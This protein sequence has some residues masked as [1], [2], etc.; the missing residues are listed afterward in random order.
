M[1]KKKTQEVHE[2]D[3]AQEMQEGKRAQQAFTVG[4]SHT[5]RYFKDYMNKDFATLSEQRQA[6]L[7]KTFIDNPVLKPIFDLIDEYMDEITV[8]ENYND[9]PPLLKHVPV[10]DFL[11][12]VRSVAA[13][14]NIKST[15]LLREILE[16]ETGA[17]GYPA[18][19]KYR[20]VVERAQKW[21]EEDHE[22]Q[23]PEGVKK[24]FE[25]IVVPVEKIDLMLDKPNTRLWD[26]IAGA[27]TNGQLYF[28]T[29]TAEMKKKDIE[30][31]IFYSI[32]FS[33]L[34]DLTIS[35]ELTPFDKL[36]YIVVG[37]LYNAGNDVIS[38]TQIYKVMGYKGNPGAS[39]LKDINDSLTKMGAAR[40]KIDNKEE[41]DAYANYE[42]T[43]KGGHKKEG[44]KHF[45]YDASLLPF[46]R[47]TA[48]INDQYTD[49]AIHVFREP[50][51]ISFARVRNQLTT[52]SQKLLE[53]PVNKTEAN[54]RLQDY[55]LTHIGRIKAG[56]SRSKMLYSTIF[57]R[58]QITDKKQKQRAP[59]KIER[60]LR[61]YVAEGWISGYK[62]EPDGVVIKLT[63]DKKK[64]P[65]KTK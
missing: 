44:Y 28:N 45:T 38:A 16:S 5:A 29:G 9:I 12:C 31:L 42:G 23:P 22:N 43:K 64:L 50:P 57:E 62:M 21:K 61:H 34:D 52:F 65:G 15:D 49:S 24:S 59:E 14:E 25:R 13:D 6:E 47:C 19:P 41:V 37:A 18:L 33:E 56:N 26:Y 40:V 36:V 54:L 7:V 10:F 27:D 32:N 55:L 60:Y 20:A 8:I 39:D 48:Y 53:S 3:L 58:C 51:L 17:D 30:A 4:D 11:E 2:V 63:A 35:K 1:A 46:E